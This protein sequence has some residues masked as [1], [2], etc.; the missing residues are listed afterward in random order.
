MP[1]VHMHLPIPLF[2]FA[3]NFM[4]KKLFIIPES[5]NSPRYLVCFM[6]YIQPFDL[7]GTYLGVWP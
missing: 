1:C 7:S 3:F 4:L 2:F 6:F 5:D